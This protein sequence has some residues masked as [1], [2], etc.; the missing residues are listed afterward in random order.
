M[1]KE[2]QLE[3]HEVRALIRGLLEKVWHPI[4]NVFPYVMAT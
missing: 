3:P 4:N 1:V 2:A